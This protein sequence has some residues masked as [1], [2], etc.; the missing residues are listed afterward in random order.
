MEITQIQKPINRARLTQNSPTRHTYKLGSFIAV[1]RDRQFCLTDIFLLFLPGILAIL[2]PL[3]YGIYQAGRIYSRFGPTAM[4]PNTL[5]WFCLAATGGIIFGSLFVYRLTLSK[6]YVALYQ[7]GLLIN[8]GVKRFYPWTQIKAIQSC[9]NKIYFV[10]FELKE[11]YRCTLFL[12]NG[13]NLKISKSI[14]NFPDLIDNLKNN[15]YPIIK[16]D[17]NDMFIKGKWLNFGSLKIQ[18]NS[19]KFQSLRAPWNLVNRITLSSGTLVIELS[20]HKTIHIPV[21]GI[22]NLELLLQIINSGVSIQASST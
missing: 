4:L 13:K 18:K 12:N 6:N 17:L 16:P 7:T 2:A 9:K 1:Y 14:K 10:F 20:N 5:F 21:C 19:F 22:P 15:I 8:N 3:F 11:T